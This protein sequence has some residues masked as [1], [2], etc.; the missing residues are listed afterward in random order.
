MTSASDPTPPVPLVTNGGPP[1]RVVI[2]ENHQ[3]V[4]DSLSAL[5]DG[6]TD[7]DVVGTAR[8]VSE[9]S[10]LPGDLAPHVALMDFHL[11]D[12]TGRDAALAMRVLFPTVRFIFLSRDGSDDARLSA[13]EAGASAYLHKSDAAAQVVNAV[14]KVAQ[15]W[16]LIPPSTVAELVTNGHDHEVTRRSLSS[17]EREVLHLLAKGVA[18]RQIAGRLG[19]S[20]STV[21]THIRSIN[22]KLGA[23]SMV[24]AV[25]TARQLEMVS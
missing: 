19:I 11:G 14:R 8:S 2:V 18:T 24:N 12:G 25:N 6:Q 4:S 22:S 5:L 10:S 16:S 9:A 3:V 17:R 7:M 1:I 20:Y 15:G 13:V 21:R 23:K